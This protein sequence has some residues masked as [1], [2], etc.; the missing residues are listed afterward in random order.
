MLLRE[1]WVWLGQWGYHKGIEMIKFPNITFKYYKIEISILK[2][3]NIRP[4]H[5]R[6]STIVKKGYDKKQFLDVFERYI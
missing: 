4:K 3:F 6:E 5:I 1:T 2:P